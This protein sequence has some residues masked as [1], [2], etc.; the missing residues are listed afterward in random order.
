MLSIRSPVQKLNETDDFSSL[1]PIRIWPHTR[2]VI[3][4]GLGE[5]EGLDPYLKDFEQRPELEFLLIER[6]P[7]HF[8]KLLENIDI[9]SW[10]KSPRVRIWLGLTS[11]QAQLSSITYFNENNRAAYWSAIQIVAH[12]E[13]AKENEEYFR[14][15]EA[16][17]NEAMKDASNA[18][19]NSPEDAFL[20][21][22][23]ALLDEDWI[24]KNP[25]WIQFKNRLP[26]VPA[27]LVASGPSL[28]QEF[29]RLKLAHKKGIII[30]ADSA[31]RPLLDHGIVPDFVT[32]LERV[33]EV[34]VF[35]QGP[36]PQSTIFVS[37]PVL[38]PETYRAYTGPKI[39]AFRDYPYFEIFGVN[40]TEMQMIGPSCTH[41]SFQFAHMLGCSPLVLVGQDLSY[42]PDNYRSHVRGTGFAE[43]DKSNNPEELLAKQEYFWVEGNHGKKVLTNHT[44][45]MFRAW[46]ENLFA[47]IED[48]TIINCS[49][50][51]SKIKYC[52]VESLQSVLN[53]L[54]RN[55]DR[56]SFQN[57]MSSL[58]ASQERIRKLDWINGLKEDVIWI[59][60]LQKL[61]DAGLNQASNGQANL[62]IARA[63]ETMVLK[64]VNSDRHFKKL[65]LMIMTPVLFQ[66]EV[67]KNEAASACADDALYINILIEHYT[68]MLAEIKLWSLKLKNLLL[69]TINIDT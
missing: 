32:A 4:F 63:L 33:P 3:F 42:D 58:T 66:I 50:K 65:L 35:F 30:C 56:A 23:N 9:S 11:A 64:L 62:A 13:I 46:F 1:P 21:L 34:A 53:G 20:G 22:E 5:G 68:Q 17:C 61:L 54:T 16:S 31:L 57:K 39:M 59:D 45:A 18:F 60:R 51:G 27:F 6:K 2:L 14:N 24:R 36:I 8:A 41:L 7:E 19:G 52:S 37:L 44:L 40:E 29:D 43:R 48:R 69:N 12:P 26:E 28:E 10:L 38:Y 25:S 15:I 55:W 47:R 67:K 49:L